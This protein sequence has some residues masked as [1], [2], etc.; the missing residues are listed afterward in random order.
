VCHGG[1]YSRDSQN[2]KGFLRTCVPALRRVF[3]TFRHEQG[4]VKGAS[5]VAGPPCG[6]AAHAARGDAGFSGGCLVGWGIGS[7]ISHETSVV[8]PNHRFG[9]AF[10]D[11]VLV[12]ATG[13]A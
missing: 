11:V 9:G 4:C 3:S 7:D 2:G 10:E 13:R 1:Q 5:A 6:R 8:D 12:G